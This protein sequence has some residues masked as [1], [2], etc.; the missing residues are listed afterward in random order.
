MISRHEAS[1]T[2]YIVSAYSSAGCH[3]DFQCYILMKK[4]WRAFRDTFMDE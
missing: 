2:D 3:F 4:E 1:D